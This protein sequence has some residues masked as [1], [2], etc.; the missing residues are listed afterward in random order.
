MVKI[1]KCPKKRD[2]N[3]KDLT[4]RLFLF[5]SNK[6]SIE[7]FSTDAVFVYTINGVYDDIMSLLNGNTKTKKRKK[8]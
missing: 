6:E 5:I 3:K 2:F 1:N 4:T 7:A 8:L